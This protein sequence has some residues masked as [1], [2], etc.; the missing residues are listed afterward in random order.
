MSGKLLPQEPGRLFWVLFVL[1]ALTYVGMQVTGSAL[2]NDIAPGGIVTFELI[3]SMAG[4]QSIMDSWQGP[5][6]TWAG[7]NMGLDFLF[8]VLYSLTISLG[9]V[10]LAEK[11]PEKMQKLKR[12]GQGMSRIVFLAAGLDIVENIA[13]MTLLTGSQNDYLPALARWCAIPKFGLV[14]IALLYVMGAGLV[15]LAKP[16]KLSGRAA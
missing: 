12:V 3:G 5:S 6:M 2:V 8:L 9:C 15:V 10:I 11:L 13:L 16:K 14:L 1:T 7:M 4:S